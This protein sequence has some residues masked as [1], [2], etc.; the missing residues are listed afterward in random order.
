MVNVGKLH[1]LITDMSFKIL[2]EVEWLKQKVQLDCDYN[3]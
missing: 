2:E 1:V 3:L